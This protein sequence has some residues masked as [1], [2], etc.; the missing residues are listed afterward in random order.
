VQAAA[1]A[2]RAYWLLTDRITFKLV[3]S[4]SAG[5]LTVA[6]LVAQPELGPPPH[7]HQRQDETFYILGGLWEFMYEGR[8]FTAG[9]GSIVHMARAKLHSHRAVGHA[10]GTALVMYTP[11]GLEHFVEEAGTPV[12]DPAATPALPPMPEIERVVSIA[13]RH[14]IEV[15]PS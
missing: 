7:I 12:V 14:G 4:E 5:M 2:T 8:T 1:T 15:P 9:P 6:E 10:P 11:S 13:A 3:G